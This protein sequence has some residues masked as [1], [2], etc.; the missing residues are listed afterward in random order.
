MCSGK[1]LPGFFQ[2]LLLWQ[3]RCPDVWSLI[4]DL[5]Q[6]LSSRYLGG[7]LRL[8]AQGVLVLALTGRL[9]LVLPRFYEL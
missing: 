8:C 9:F 5:P 1:A 6:K 7:V 3:G 2:T 4:R